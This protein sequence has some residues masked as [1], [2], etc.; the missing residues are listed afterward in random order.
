MQDTRGLIQW[1]E[2]DQLLSDEVREQ[3]FP[4]GAIT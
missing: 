1:V 4:M 2:I 3:L